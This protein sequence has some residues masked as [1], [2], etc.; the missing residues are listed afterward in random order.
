MLFGSVPS[1]P[2]TPMSSI[3]TQSARQNTASMATAGPATARRPVSSAAAARARTT[4][5]IRLTAN[6]CPA[7]RWPNP[8]TRL[9]SG[10][11]CGV[12]AIDRI[13]P[14]SGPGPPQ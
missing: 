8:P 7:A 14:A 12:C 9:A 10:R 6:A 13:I 4:T 11:G 5:A 2:N 1:P 3:S